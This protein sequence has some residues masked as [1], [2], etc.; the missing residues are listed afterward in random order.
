[1]SSPSVIIVGA[2]PVVLTTALSLHQGGISARD[3]L[4]ADERP[5]RDLT[6]TWSKSISMSAS[7]LE[8]F[9]ILGL[10]EHFIKSGRPLYTQHFGAGAQLLYLN[11]DVL[12]TK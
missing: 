1:M 6:T 4:V 12:G 8:V 11:Y 9:R 10:D 7:S 2:G 3:I 5:S